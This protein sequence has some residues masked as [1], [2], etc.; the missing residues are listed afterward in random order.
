MSEASLQPPECPYPSFDLQLAHRRVYRGSSL[1]RDCLILGPY[2][3]PMPRA[4]RKPWGGGSFS[5]ARYPCVVH[6]A[7]DVT[8]NNVIVTN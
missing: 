4:L 3:R 8:T 6:T 1:I 5:R 7:W 2:I